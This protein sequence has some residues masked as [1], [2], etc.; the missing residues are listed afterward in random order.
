MCTIVLTDVADK[1]LRV[2]D[3]E[4]YTGSLRC[5]QGSASMGE[6]RRG[7]GCGCDASLVMHHSLAVA[8]HMY[9][10]PRFSSPTLCSPALSLAS[11]ALSTT[12][13]AL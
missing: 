1:E 11:G 10:T 13:G 5:H 7:A 3:A 2:F 8:A 9:E 4:K 12:L 6:M